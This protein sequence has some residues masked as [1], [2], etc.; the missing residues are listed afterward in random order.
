M[1]YWRLIGSGVL[2]LGLWLLTPERAW[3]SL[4]TCDREKSVHDPLSL[5]G[6]EL[7][8]SVLRNGKPIGMHRVTFDRDGDRLMVDSRF[9][10]EV[11]VLF[12]TAFEYVYESKS[13]WRDG[14]MVELK[15]T[16]NDNGDRSRVT[17]R[18]TDGRLV[19]DGPAGST[20]GIAGLFPTDH[21]HS[22]VLGGG[23]VLNTIT[24]RVASVTISD[25][26]ESRVR[27]NN[28]SIPARHY[29]YSGDLQTDVWYDENGRW[30]KMQFRAE[31]GSKIE[32]VCQKCGA[33]GVSDPA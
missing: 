32:Y 22:G 30:V 27:V 1:R 7:L 29:V 13:I 20:Q 21:W 28:G 31:D 14:C 2:V 16:T 33:I 6:N 11:K 3:S 15:A 25:M 9:Q 24:G 10:A 5:Y 17:A 8:F 4:Y 18:L 19:I 23:Q 26:G 12:F